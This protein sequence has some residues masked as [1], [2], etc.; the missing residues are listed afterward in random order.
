MIELAVIPP[1]AVWQ[2]AA[3]Y[4]ERSALFSPCVAM[5]PRTRS[6]T[7]AAAGAASGDCGA[8]PCGRPLRLTR[9][10]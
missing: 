1:L 8:S 3:V 4:L 7:G 9:T 6:S 2:R 5:P 10:P